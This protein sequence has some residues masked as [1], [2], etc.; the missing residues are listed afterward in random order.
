MAR[1]FSELRISGFN[2][3]V[4][5]GTLF[6]AQGVNSQKRNFTTTCI[7][8]FFSD[9]TIREW[10]LVTM[11]SVRVLHGHKGPVRDIKVNMSCWK[12]EWPV[13]PEPAER[14]FL[15]FRPSPCYTM[16]YNKGGLE[17]SK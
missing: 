9:G 7:C 6:E 13:Q 16:L 3:G 5:G 12:I 15:G 8:V 14:S 4:S 10:D 2:F 11:T 1:A 17:G